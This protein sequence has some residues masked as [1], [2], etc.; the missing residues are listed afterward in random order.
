M[1]IAAFNVKGGPSCVLSRW[2]LGV[3]VG[4]LSGCEKTV[5]R[6]GYK[7]LAL[8]RSEV[9]FYG[10]SITTGFEKIERGFYVD[11]VH[12]SPCHQT[13]QTPPYIW[14]FGKSPHSVE[15]CH[16]L[17]PKYL[18]EHHR[19]ARPSRI[20]RLLAASN[21]RYTFPTELELH[22]PSRDGSP[23]LQTWLQR[24]RGIWKGLARSRRRTPSVD[25]KSA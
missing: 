19:N 22:H 11:R 8:W 14:L 5:R 13:L 9:P 2:I 20:P 12:P 6:A 4:A 15:N 25:A 23:A 17:P 18:M 16:V 10:R 3:I 1:S 7:E 24:G 21:V